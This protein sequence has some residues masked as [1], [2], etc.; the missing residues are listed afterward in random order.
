MRISGQQVSV[1]IQ[2][3]ADVLTAMVVKGGFTILS[4]CHDHDE[5]DHSAKKLK[6]LLSSKGPVNGI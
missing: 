3:A 4:Y 2:I 1:G 5:W 6:E